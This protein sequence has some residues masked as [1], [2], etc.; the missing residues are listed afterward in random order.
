MYEY[1]EPCQRSLYFLCFFSSV[2]YTA[3]WWIDLEIEI[4]IA[5]WLLIAFCTEMIEANSQL[6][7]NWAIK[8]GGPKKLCSFCS[9]IWLSSGTPKKSPILLL[10]R[11][12]AGPLAPFFVAP[13][14][15]KS[16]KVNSDGGIDSKQGAKFWEKDQNRAFLGVF[17]HEN[18][19]SKSKFRSKEAELFWPPIL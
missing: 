8:L 1:Y 3:R 6:R 15:V 17:F 12:G 4:L 18:I 7:R 14:I 9:K 5:Y 10:I 13:M 16:K 2:W 11:G 19:S